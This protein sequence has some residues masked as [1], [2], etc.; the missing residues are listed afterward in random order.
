M[1]D[2]LMLIL[3]VGAFVIGSYLFERFLFGPM[4]GSKSADG[5]EYRAPKDWR[6]Q[7]IL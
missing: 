7:D 2:T 5:T 3:K 4:R 6:D 1:S